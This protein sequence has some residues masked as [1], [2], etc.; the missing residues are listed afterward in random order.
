MEVPRGEIIINKIFGK[1]NYIEK[2]KKRKLK[3][4]E[5]VYK[6][7][8]MGGFNLEQSISAMNYE[9]DKIAKKYASRTGG[10]KEKKVYNIEKVDILNDDI[11]KTK[12][13]IKKKPGKKIFNKKL[14]KKT[15]PDKSLDEDDEW[16]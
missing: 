11:F 13:E 1:L 15:V 4:I 16:D 7:Q 3:N 2:S 9:M 8:S 6:K 14:K 5:N 10:E 12:D